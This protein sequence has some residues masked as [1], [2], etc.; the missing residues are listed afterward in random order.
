MHLNDIK[1]ITENDGIYK[2]IQ[3]EEIKGIAS[4]KVFANNKIRWFAKQTA[5]NEYESEDEIIT[6]Y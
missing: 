6:N 3:P 1:L 4:I 5:D 2:W